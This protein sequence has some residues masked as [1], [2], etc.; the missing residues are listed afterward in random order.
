MV[1][2]LEVRQIALLE[3]PVEVEEE[4]LKLDLSV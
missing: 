2:D 1:E 3:V 4:V